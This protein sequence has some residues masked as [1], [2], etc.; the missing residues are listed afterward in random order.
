MKAE[1]DKG[2]LWLWK[3]YILDLLWKDNS[4]KPLLRKYNY[5]TNGSAT[6]SGKD[7]ISFYYTIDGYPKDIDI[8]F[9]EAIRQ[10]AGDGVKISFI[11]TFEPT[12][13]DWD[14]ASMV[15]KLRTWKSLSEEEEDV[16]EFNY[17]E[18]LRSLDSNE[19][20]RQSLLYLSDAEL[21][22]RRN[23]F[24][25]RT[26]IIISGKRGEVFDKTI[27]KVKEY[28]SNIGLLITRVDSNLFE[29]LSAFSPFSMEMTNNVVKGVGSNT[30]P[31][32]LLARFSTYD[33][34]KIGKRGVY[35]GTDIYS[36]F[37]VYKV[38]KKDSVDAENILITAETGAGK[39]FFL[40]VLLIQLIA[41][42]KYNGTINDIEGFEYTPYAGFIA[43]NDK[44]IIIN[45]AEG[46]G[47]YFDPVEI[48]LTGNKQLDEDMFSLSKSFT[49][50]Y[51]KTLIGDV[52]DK[53]PWASVIVDDAVALLYASMGVKIDDMSTWRRSEGYSLFDGYQMFKN[54]Y[55]ECIKYS[56]EGEI[57][58]NVKV[59]DI[60]LTSEY[61]KNKDYRDTLDIVV[62][63]LSKYFEP[64]EKGGTRSEVFK[65]K[66]TLEDIVGAK[67]AVCSFGM[68]G[69]SAD[70]VDPIQMSLS[71]LS[72]A[73]ISHLRSIFSKAQGKFNFKVW[74]EFQRWG[75][76]PDSEKTIKTAITG[77][78][79]L[80]DINF[81]V[82]NDVKELLHQDRFGIFGNITS[83]AIGAISDNDI[84]KELMERLSV[85]LLKPDLDALVTKKG[86]T[87][88][89]ESKDE[90]SSMYDKAFLV[91]LDKS[92]STI[93]KMSL[94]LHIA[95][96]NIFRT[97]VDVK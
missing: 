66:V 82:T 69:K 26:M 44:V 9:K 89:Y 15:S 57:K 8:N 30:I 11:S 60:D 88:S 52:L 62:A 46:Q 5:Y 78:R 29:Y 28:C 20:R 54:L 18:K 51:Y 43:N 77:G 84:R 40:K 32:E 83:F 27:A 87:E 65:K 4:S 96:S 16:D 17:R 42:D 68:A 33:Q 67:L 59:E 85:P 56:L 2:M 1:K 23:L 37:P 12:K 71:Q 81:V 91:H 50:S 64:L 95:K 22:R 80:G 93:A 94:P 41:D 76:F 97:G 53:Y 14:S 39:S 73:N 63:K 7:N 6:F 34:G 25:Y 72:A 86:N 75:G 3:K 70:T 24:R 21:R 49:L 31:D 45:M 13:I 36:G 47:C 10:E 90:I 74:E 35:W 58:K 92:V 61:K 38:F 48:K 19:W 55:S 79:K